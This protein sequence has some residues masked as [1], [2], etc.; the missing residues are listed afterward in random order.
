V[1]LEAKDLVTDDEKGT[2]ALLQRISVF[3]LR[4]VEEHK[5][6]WDRLITHHSDAVLINTSLARR[7]ELKR[8]ADR[9]GL[10][11]RGI[12]DL[13]SFNFQQGEINARWMLDVL[14]VEALAVLVLAVEE[15]AGPMVAGVRQKQAAVETVK[16]LGG[17]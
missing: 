4:V 1:A 3:L 9:V 6:A 14:S 13:S 16:K 11:L 2:I 17:R 10:V 5:V 7:A 8:I 15:A 12:D